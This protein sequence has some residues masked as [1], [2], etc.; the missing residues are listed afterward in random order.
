WDVTRISSWLSEIGM[1][2]YVE[3]F[4]ANHISGIVLDDLDYSL[5]REVGVPT[6]GDQKRILLAIER[7]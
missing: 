4:A 6:V 1:A 2:K 5:L 3:A 7:L